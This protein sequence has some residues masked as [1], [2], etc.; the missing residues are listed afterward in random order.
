MMKEQIELIPEPAA[1]L[2]TVHCAG[3]ELFGVLE[4][5]RNEKAEVVALNAVCQSDYELHYRRRHGVTSDQ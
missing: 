5:L 4:R 3:P 1:R 2:E